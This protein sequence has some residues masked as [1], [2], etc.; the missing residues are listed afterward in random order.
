M[1]MV[2]SYRSS[3]PTQAALAGA[4]LSSVLWMTAARAGPLSI[5]LPG[6]R[7]FPE[8]ITSARDGSLFV[9]RLGEGG[10]VR[11]DPRT[12]AAAVFVAPGAADS[13]SITG[14]FADD[15]SAT[16][17][18]CSNNLS[19]LGG[20]SEGH[21]QVAALKAFDLRTG[22]AKRSVPLSGPHSFCNDIAVD[23]GGA[24]YVTDSANPTVLRLPAGASGFEVFA[25]N[26]QFAP[27]QPNSA[28]LDGIAFGGDGALYVTTY[29]AGGFFRISV[30]NGRAG[31]VIKLQGPAL[32]FPDGLRPLGRNSFLL[33]EGAGNLDRVE[34]DGDEFRVAPLC[35]G[36]RTPTSVTRVGYVAW[37][38]EG[39]M[40]LFFDPAR[41]G[42][43]LALPFR[44]YAVPLNKGQSQ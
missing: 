22:A 43:S 25:T 9:G 13:R 42:L 44:I 29:A 15:T 30:E 7:A 2:S 6:E 27:P 20:T 35:A 11:A 36:F 28:G 37:V 14:V 41:K 24:I 18:A 16:L 21:D 40:P 1:S 19:A 39:Q 4:L 23:P 38:S 8:S 32:G 10:I 34:V 33:V 12:G 17:W 3:R 31:R 26:P 5:A